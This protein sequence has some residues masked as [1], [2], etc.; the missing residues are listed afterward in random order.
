VLWPA[1]VAGTDELRAAFAEAGVR[2]V[3]LDQADEEE[4]VV[5]GEDLE[6]DYQQCPP[7][8]RDEPAARPFGLET[9]P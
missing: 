3:S 5:V 9:W 4:V 2:G 6:F 7:V 8:A 1:L